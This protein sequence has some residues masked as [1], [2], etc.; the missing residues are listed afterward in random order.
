[1]IR[2]LRE[3]FAHDTWWSRLLVAS[4]YLVSTFLYMM[5]NRLASNAGRAVVFKFALDDQIPL[6]P[7]FALF[8]Y[9]WFAL[10]ASVFLWLV[11]ARRTGRAIDRHAAAIVLAMILSALVF[12]VYPTHVPRPELSGDTFF[13]RLVLLIYSVDEPYNCFPSLH[14]AVAAL[15]GLT[16][17]RFGPRRTVFRLAAT[18]LVILIMLAT[19]LIKQHFTPDMLG[20]LALALLCDR[21]AALLVKKK[22]AKGV[23]R[24][25]KT[26]QTRYESRNRNE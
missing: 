7:F 12:I 4:T 17:Y 13:T 16:L 14:V 10:V 11:F 22:P 26:E 24:Q 21:L 8:Y 18:I 25:E 6:V 1:M 15:N 2:S 5:T 3:G 19:V 23:V 20:I 9:A